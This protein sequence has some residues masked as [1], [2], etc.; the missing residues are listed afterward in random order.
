MH[1]V[2]IKAAKELLRRTD[3]SI[4]AIAQACGYSNDTSFYQRL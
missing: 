3:Q 1:Q 2:R 4:S